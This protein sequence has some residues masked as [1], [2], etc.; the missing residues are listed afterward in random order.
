[1]DVIAK[2]NIS[3]PTGRKIVRELEKHKKIV[4]L[5]YPVSFDKSLLPDET[6]FV[7]EAFIELE[8]KLKNIMI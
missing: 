8:E 1:M 7:K 3:T 4:K 6:F 2:I 5:S